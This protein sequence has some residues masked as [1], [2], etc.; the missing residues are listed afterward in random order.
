[1]INRTVYHK[2]DISTLV[3]GDII[4]LGRQMIPKDWH[5]WPVKVYCGYFI[6]F[7]YVY[8]TNLPTEKA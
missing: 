7:L 2:G 3:G 6:V 5:L 4:I 1:M 8:Q